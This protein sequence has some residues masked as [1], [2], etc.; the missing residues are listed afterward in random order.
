MFSSRIT[1]RRYFVWTA[2]DCIQTLFPYL[3]VDPGPPRCSEEAWSLFHALDSLPWS[4]L[5]A[6]CTSTSPCSMA[7]HITGNNASRFVSSKW[8]LTLLVARSSVMISWFI[9]DIGACLGLGPPHWVLHYIAPRMISLSH[10]LSDLS[11]ACL[12]LELP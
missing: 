5:R 11:H 1:L 6:G 7:L 8:E 4:V 9:F 12:A 2:P 10:V 3:R